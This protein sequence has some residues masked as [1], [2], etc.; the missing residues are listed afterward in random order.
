VIVTACHNEERYGNAIARGK[1]AYLFREELKEGLPRDWGEGKG[2][3]GTVETQARAL[4]AG[5]NEDGN[6]LALKEGFADRARPEG[7]VVLRRGSGY[8]HDAG[9]TDIRRG[10]SGVVGV[11]EL[12]VKGENKAKVKAP[13]ILEEDVPL[14]RGERSIMVENV[15][16]A[17]AFEA[18]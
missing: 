8:A 17:V 1:S 14:V 15:A 3:F 18:L 10:A 11:R 5:D 6:F 13:A 9:G 12:P 16:L 7:I 2:A 4:S